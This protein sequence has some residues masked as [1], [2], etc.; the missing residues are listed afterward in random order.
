MTYFHI[1]LQNSTHFSIKHKNKQKNKN[2]A[3]I[4]SVKGGEISASYL[5]KKFPFQ[6]LCHP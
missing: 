6:K 3:F 2:F 4:A 5:C 1:N